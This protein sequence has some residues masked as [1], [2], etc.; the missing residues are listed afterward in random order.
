MACNH[1]GERNGQ[2][3]LRSKTGH[4]GSHRY[5]FR[6]PRPRTSDKKEQSVL[7][8]A[9]RLPKSATAALDRYADWLAKPGE[10]MYAEIQERLR[11]SR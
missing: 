5:R 6:P 4:A 2:P 9:P 3:C 10:T 8:P 1:I 7:V 11:R